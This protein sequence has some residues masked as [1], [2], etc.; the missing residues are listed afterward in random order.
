MSAPP[1]L[2]LH[3]FGTT[4][5]T[6]WGE[7]GWIDLLTDSGRTVIAVDLLGHGTAPTPHDPAAYDRNG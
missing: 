5:A 4:A 2:L 6:T 3:G 7:N 1:V